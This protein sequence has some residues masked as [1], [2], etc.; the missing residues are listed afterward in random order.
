MQRHWYYD[1]TVYGTFDEAES[2]WPSSCHVS[3]IIIKA[4]GI[5]TFWVSVLWFARK[6]LLVFDD[7]AFL[8]HYVHID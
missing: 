6:G 5:V 7:G 1:G 2:E 3:R 4:Q 8:A